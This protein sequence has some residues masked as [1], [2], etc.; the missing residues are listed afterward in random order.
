VPGAALCCPGVHF[1]EDEAPW[2]AAK[3][4]AGAN[5]HA[6]EPGEAA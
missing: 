6:E 5:K 1:W 4:P 3:E 2:E